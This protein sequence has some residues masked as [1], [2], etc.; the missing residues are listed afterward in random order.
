MVTYGILFPPPTGSSR[1]HHA[2]PLATHI[3]H[4]LGDVFDDLASERY[5]FV[6][7]R[8]VQPRAGGTR[9]E[10]PPQGVI[11]LAASASSDIPG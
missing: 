6:L 9:T 3:Q 10:R 1:T 4:K 11:T 8:V 7:P 5:R 2:P